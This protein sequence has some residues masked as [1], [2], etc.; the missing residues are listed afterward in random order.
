MAKQNEFQRL[1]QTA[2]GQADEDARRVRPFFIMLTG[3][4]LF[5]YAW[6][7]AD[8]PRLHSASL[9]VALFTLLM[10]VYVVLFWLSPRWAGRRPQAVIY[11][12]VQGALAFTLVILVQNTASIFGVFAALVGVSVGMLGR[13]RALVV[14]VVLEMGLSAL[15]FVLIEGSV[16]LGVWIL[17]TGPVVIFVLVYVTMYVREIEARSRAQTLLQELEVANR[18]AHGICCASGRFDAGQRTPTY[19]TRTA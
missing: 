4:M 2:L 16:S 18:Q 9:L 17:S 15:C 19:G 14:A 7:V 12:V 11:L 1:W 5:I 3:A 13:T 6:S 8:S 10:I